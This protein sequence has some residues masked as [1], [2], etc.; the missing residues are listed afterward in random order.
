MIHE[1]MEKSQTQ[2][3]YTGRLGRQYDFDVALIARRWVR[4][5]IV[6]PK[7]WRPSPHGG[8]LGRP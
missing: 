6:V 1:G 8:R 5:R 7:A 3:S 4:V 2:I